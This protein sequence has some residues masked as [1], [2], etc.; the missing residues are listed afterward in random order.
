MDLPR[1]FAAC[2][3][4]AMTGGGLLLGSL[5]AGATTACMVV[6]E[7]T[8]FPSSDLQAAIQAAAPGDTLSVHGTC[9]GHFVI[10]KDL[11]LVGGA[12]LDGNHT[13]RPLTV[14]AGNVLLR[15]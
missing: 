1:P 12:T 10:A 5:P 2:A 6:N 4:L 15:Q 11:T 9:V 13:E 8:G 7:R 14:D 3:A